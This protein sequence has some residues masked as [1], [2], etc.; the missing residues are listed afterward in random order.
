MHPD[1]AGNKG[2]K[3]R[4]GFASKTT[5]SSMAFEAEFECRGIAKL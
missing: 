2:D 3:D 5:S 4:I 1:G